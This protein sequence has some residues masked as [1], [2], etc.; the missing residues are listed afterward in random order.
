M[1]FVLNVLYLFVLTLLSPWL[2]WRG[3]R[4]GRYRKHLGAKLFG[5]MTVNNPERKPVAW[6][7]AVSVGEVHLLG[8]VVAAFRKRH[9]DWCIV[10]SSTTDT[11]LAEATARF[12]DC[13]VIAYPF[14]FSWACANAIRAVNPTIILLAESEM[15]PNFLAAAARRKIPVVLFNARQSPRS[16]GRLKKIAGLAR[17][18]LFRHVSLFAVQ[19]QDYAERFKLL[20]VPAEKLIVTG[21]VKYDG[22][23][24]D[25][26]SPKAKELARLLVIERDNPIIWVAGSTHAP[27]E[28]IILDLFDKLIVSHPALILILVP[29]HPDRFE[30]VAM[31]CADHDLYFAR[32]S[33]LT[34]R[35]SRPPCILLLD[36]IGELG[37]AWSLA[38]IGYTGGSLDGHRGGQSMIEPAGY[39]VPTLFGP[40]VWN[41]RDAANR[42]IEAGGAIKVA[43]AAE[44]KSKMRELLAD[45]V[46]R[47]EMGAKAKA[48]VQAQ[49]GAT[50]RTLDAIDQIIAHPSRFRSGTEPAP[51]IV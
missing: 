31:M 26:D 16:F 33:K 17:Q 18:L 28:E 9:P 36:T 1:S 4:T 44:L 29:R 37:A 19:S 35:P 49:Q 13:S 15:W 41:F 45:P 27:E 40:H 14:D 12:P 6:F 25:R 24:G 8:T 10:I 23:T 22:A 2:V 48:L 34:D 3:L 51:R 21:S 50:E 20:G 7:H 39:G 38:D 43:D 42:L 46:R 47:R 30:E 11:G 32:R 5:R